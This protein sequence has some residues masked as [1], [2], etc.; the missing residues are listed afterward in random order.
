MANKLG[1]VLGIIIL[2]ADLYWTATSYRVAIWLALGIII[3]IADVIWI[4][5]DAKGK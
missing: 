4:A 5:I 3:F 1:V 2:I